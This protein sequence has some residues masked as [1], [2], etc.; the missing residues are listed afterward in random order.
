MLL[1]AILQ[2]ETWP[3]VFAAVATHVDWYAAGLGLA[4]RRHVDPAGA[5]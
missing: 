5:S 1:R 3:G 2:E 4:G